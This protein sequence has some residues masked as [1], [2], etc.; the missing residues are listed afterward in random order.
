MGDERDRAVAA[1]LPA[2]YEAEGVVGEGGMATVFRARDT[3]LGRSVA[4]KVLRPELALQLGAS[5]FDREIEITRR[6][7][8]V[9]VLPVLDSGVA[10][11]LPFYVMPLVEGESL[12]QRIAREGEL[13]IDEA[14]DVTLQVAGALSAAHELGIV[15]RDVK[16][17][18]I[19]LTGGRPLVADFGIAHLLDSVDDE[20]LT[21]S[22]TSVGT[23]G[24][25]SPEQIS[26]HRDVDAR[27]DVYSLGCVLYEMLA[28]EP[29]FSGRTRQAIYAKQVSFATPLVGKVRE[30]VPLAVEEVV[31]RALAKSP[32]DRFES[33]DAFARALERARSDTRSRV[34]TD[35]EPRSPRRL[36]IVAAGVVVATAIWASWS[37]LAAPAPAAEPD[38]MR[39]AVLPVAAAGGLDVPVL[40]AHVRDALARWV[41]VSV[42]DPFALSERLPGDGAELTQSAAAQV[43]LDL[44]ARWLVRVATGPVGD[45]ARIQ[46]VLADALGGGATSLAHSVRIGREDRVDGDLVA[47][48]VDHVLLNAGGALPDLP[49]GTRSL[50]AARLFLEGRR[51]AAEWDLERAVASFASA[52]EQDPSFSRAHLW[53]ALVRW[54]AGRPP[55][56]WTVTLT[57]AS[58]GSE[59]LRER[60]RTILDAL[61]SLSRSAPELACPTW[62]RLAEDEPND[63][64]GWYAYAQ[65]IASDDAVVTDPHS[66]SGY[67]F[68]TSYQHALRAYQ[69]A[70]ALQPAVLASMREDSY[71]DLRRLLHLGGSPQRRVGSGDEPSRQFAADPVW[72]GDSLGFVPYPLREGS[73]QLTG[74]PGEFLEAKRHLSE[75]FRD[76]A[77]AW[78]TADPGS[79]D[80]RTALALALALLGEGVALDTLRSAKAMATTQE[81]HRSVTTYEL[82]MQ[83][84]FSLPSDTLGLRRVKHLAD[85]MLAADGDAVRGE[86]WTLAGMAALTGRAQVLYRLSVHPATSGPLRVPTAL[87]GTAPALL[88]L[89]ALGGPADSLRVL[90]TRVRRT[91]ERELVE[92]ERPRATL[93]WLVRPATLAFP[94][95]RFDAYRDLE[96]HNDYLWDMQRAWTLGDTAAVLEGLSGLEEMRRQ[97]PPQ[98][99]TMD[100]V[101]PEAHL[102]A[103]LGDTARAIEW[104]DPP[105][106]ALRLMPPSLVS[107]PPFAGSLAR[108][109]ALRA[110]LAAATD[111]GAAAGWAR[112]L[113]I[114]WE[115]ADAFLQPTLDEMRRLVN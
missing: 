95:Q 62:R 96:V 88:A 43:A 61:E 1:A 111:A 5:R 82:W 106:G 81:E 25:M 16:P 39:F 89:S 40:D 56:Q 7:S 101:Y 15:H 107:Q 22:G 19:F 66:P 115:D 8:H 36:G 41:D 46:I 27:T 80:A 42:V 83:L 13:P 100:G 53:T 48:L 65:C 49:M 33:M 29:P 12:A 97:I 78:A 26:A 105:L 113:L 109:L 47:S 4:V 45:S 21:E 90:E 58:L 98:S 68:R 30:T 77:A 6:L 93:E 71:A 108:A 32:A 10:G 102:L 72:Q 60:D 79:V 31:T 74:S 76:I 69:R 63:F 64:M 73:L 114:L 14:I 94:H 11:D 35:V 70:F 44:G 104:L 55:A 34:R 85:S 28:G 54:W 67:A 91:I 23:P 51:A 99:L 9:N 59:G 18:N 52:G 57:R 2:R 37:Y 92:D 86:P 75:L 38:A 17:S 84:A 110:R 50:G 24:Y 103:E 112:A 20:R 3:L 87:R